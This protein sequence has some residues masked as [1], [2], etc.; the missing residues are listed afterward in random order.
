[1]P[2]DRSVMAGTSFWYGGLFLASAVSW[3]I[4]IPV[5]AAAQ[6][7][8]TGAIQFIRGE[9]TKIDGTNYSVHL[10]SGRNALVP[11]DTNTSM[12]C[13]SRPP[14]EKEVLQ[15]QDRAKHR[16]F[17]IGDCPFQV[18]DMVKVETTSEGRA[19]FIRYLSHPAETRLSRLGLPYKYEGELREPPVAREGNVGEKY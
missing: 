2:N 16:G 6:Q 18:G 9:I 11:V 3:L 17:R 15:E 1:M 13:P 12:V 19:T 8:A 7:S 14:E 4:G 5:S 10:P